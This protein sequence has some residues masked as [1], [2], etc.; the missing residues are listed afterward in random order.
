MSK[1]HDPLHSAEAILEGDVQ[2]TRTTID[3]A[4]ADAEAGRDGLNRTLGPINLMALGVAAVVGAGVFVVTGNAAATKAGPAVIISFIIA[5]IVAALSAMCYSELAAMIPLSGS[6]YSYA[7]A[8]LG[9]LVAW[10]IGWDLLV[11]YLF[12]AANVANGWSGYFVNLLK[13]MGLE[14]GPQWTKAPIANAGSS[15]TGIMNLPAMLLIAFVTALLFIGTKLSG[16]ATTIFVAIKLATLALFVGVGVFFVQGDNYTPFIPEP[17]N[18]NFGWGGILAA[19]GI[20]FY[21]YISFDAVCTTA[22]ET[23][24]PRKAVPIGVL[25][26][27]GIATAI[28]VLVGFVLVGLVSYTLLNVSDPLSTALDGAGLSW[29]AEVVDVGAVIGL[30]A[31]VLALLYAQTR[32]LLRMAEDGM[33]PPMFSRIN[34]N[35]TPG[36]TTLVCGIAAAIMAGILPLSILTELISI[37]TLL[38]FIIVAAAI[39]VLRKTRPDLPRPFKLPWGY[40]IPVLAI[41]SSLVIMFSLPWETWL[42]LGVWLVIGMII[43]FVYSR[44]RALAVIAEREARMNEAARDA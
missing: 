42:R 14:L 18:G 41:V 22:Q 44:K 33:L 29:L 9:T 21:S 13:Q 16:K 39:I 25:G 17:V 19:A 12:G 30:A 40:T 26:S 15:E 43:Y 31:S 2:E 10:I 1:E 20:V 28:Y 5:G 6:T 11:E 3:M 35:H 38:A 36:A 8:A 7:Y 32:I 4:I 23:K 24:N 27:L 37:G 34:K